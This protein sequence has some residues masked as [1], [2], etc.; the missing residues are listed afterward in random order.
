MHSIAAFAATVSLALSTVALAAPAHL[1]DIQFVAANRCL[2]LLSSKRL[3][4]PDAAALKRLIDSQVAGRAPFIYDRA[5]QARED[6]LRQA[7]RGKQ[8]A[9]LTAER[10]GAC[11]SFLSDTTTASEPASPRHS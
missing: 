6:A 11:K 1:D 3:G 9:K 7:D 2:G 10:D 8:T 4:T 5:D